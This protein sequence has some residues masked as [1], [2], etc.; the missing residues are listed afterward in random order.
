[1]SAVRTRPR[2][3]TVAA[4][5]C[6]LL[7]CTAVSACAEGGP[8]GGSATSAP[9]AGSETARGDSL[10]AAPGASA[11]EK[12]SADDQPGPRESVPGD[13]SAAARA[14]APAAT[15]GSGG[16]IVATSS[17]PATSAPAPS[18]PAP[19][20]G[21]RVRA[22]R[23]ASGRKAG[24][25]AGM[26]ASALQV[27]APA[28][29]TDPPEESE[30]VARDIERTD[31]LISR[32]TALAARA[33]HPRV[34]E[35][36]SLARD[37][38]ADARDAYRLRHYARAQRLT[39]AS[40]DHAERAMRL[41]GPAVDDPDNVEVVLGRTDDALDRLKDV[42]KRGGGGQAAERG[43]EKL[44]R[45]QKAARE[46]FRE[47][48]VSGAYKATVRV[49]EGVLKLLIAISAAGAPIS[50][51]TAERAVKSAERARDRAAEDIG[52]RPRSEVAKLLASADQ[53]LAKA[54][55]LIARGNHSDALLRAKAA[56]RQL[57]RA[58]DA[59]RPARASR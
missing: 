51:D 12:P 50:R 26:I 40:R 41:I 37:F 17:V 53:H 6:W 36:L 47:G 5:A 8:A 59:A 10:N 31:V 27:A 19:A 14:P 22:P 32:A 24:A 16:A 28:P 55:A 38:Q 25:P 13:S 33:R 9:D 34:P 58:I 43:Y 42:V 1:M 45:D 11:A 52:P 56:E 48:D 44:K 7:A 4:L 30:R 49:R 3:L 2:P 23:I 18:A 20:A 15:A 21:T 54:R 39:L 35:F 29:T 46:R 57:E